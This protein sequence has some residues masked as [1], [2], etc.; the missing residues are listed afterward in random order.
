M[1]LN[2]LYSEI[3][4]EHYQNSPN[5]K[6][7]ED[8][9]IEEKGHNPLCGDVI[10]IYLKMDGDVIK[11]ASFTGQGCAISQASTSMLIDLIKGKKLEEAKKLIQEFTDMLYKKDVNLDDL[12]DAQALAG[13]ADF[14][15]RVKCALLPWKTL[16]EVVE[17]KE[18]GK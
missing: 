18:E 4:L 2:Q 15:A 17:E 3:I 8:A 12:G 10:T 6:K 9:D 1:E 13:V 11:D 7:M 16:E 5:K 14:P